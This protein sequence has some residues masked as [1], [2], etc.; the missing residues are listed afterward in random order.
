MQ[1]NNTTFYLFSGQIFKHGSNI[2]WPNTD[3]VKSVS[4]GYIF[5]A[6]CGCTIGTPHW[7]IFI[8]GS[9]I[10]L[11]CEGN[12]IYDIR[13][14]PHTYRS[15]NISCTITKS[16]VLLCRND[17]HQYSKPVFITV[18]QEGILLIVY[19]LMIISIII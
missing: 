10:E 17:C 5:N 4:S 18:T 11:S 8:N 1:Y 12:E 6:T 15:R 16:T 19:F 3:I 14:K 7:L 2:T 9:N 13:H